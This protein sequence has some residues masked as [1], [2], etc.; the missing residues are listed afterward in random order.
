[1]LTVF[2]TGCRV[3][4]R[5]QPGQIQLRNTK[6]AKQN[7]SQSFGRL[8][9]PQQTRKRSLRE[10]TQRL[11]YICRNMHESSTADWGRMHRAMYAQRLPKSL[12]RIW[13]C[14]FASWVMS[15]SQKVAPNRNWTNEI[16]RPQRR[17]YKGS[18]PSHD[19]A[20]VYTSNSFSIGLFFRLAEHPHRRN[21]NLSGP[22]RKWV[23]YSL[24]GGSGVDISDQ[25]GPQRPG[26]KRGW[27][28]SPQKGFSPK[29][30][31]KEKR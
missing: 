1:M 30:H 31:D 26:R 14:I 5:R 13:G 18:P 20:C 27:G 4:L 28:A 12:L 16:L 11:F 7:P 17:H 19:R 22:V 21:K 2:L 10:F 23:R 24:E 25:L 8:H 9:F 15:E 29:C 3:L 6:L